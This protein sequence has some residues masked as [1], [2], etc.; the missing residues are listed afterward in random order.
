MERLH[1]KII[2]MLD[3]L[4]AQF[5]FL[6]FSCYTFIA[7]LMILSVKLL[8]MLI[9][10]LSTLSVWKILTDFCLTGPTILLLWCE[11]GSFFKMLGLN[12]SSKLDWGSYIISFVKMLPKM[13]WTFLVL[14]SFFLLRLVFISIN[15]KYSHVWNTVVMFGL[16]L[17]VASWNCYTSY[18]NG[19]V[20]LLVLHLL[21]LLNPWLIAK[22]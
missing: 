1:K 2:L 5:Y 8:S 16:V 19:Y 20:G 13:L 9:I 22:L 12:C 7:L 14:W 10:L 15:V 17:F 3:L 4:K 6:N 18:K 11:N 21:P